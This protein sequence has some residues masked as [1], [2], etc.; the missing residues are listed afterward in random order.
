[1]N[2]FQLVKIHFFSTLI[3]NTAKKSDKLFSG[4]EF[5]EFELNTTPVQILINFS[6]PD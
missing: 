2:F 6:N 3:V 4:T 1:M 5:Y